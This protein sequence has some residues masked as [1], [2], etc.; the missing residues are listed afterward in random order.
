LFSV[1]AVDPEDIE[2]QDYKRDAQYFQTHP[3]QFDPSKVFITDEIIN[4]RNQA[5]PRKMLRSI[6][7]RRPLRRKALPSPSPTATNSTFGNGYQ[8]GSKIPTSSLSDNEVFDGN[9]NNGLNGDSDVAP[10][11]PKLQR[12][13]SESTKRSTSVLQKIK[14]FEARKR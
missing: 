5:K 7:E 2:T 6:S 12:S 11:V 1:L 13:Q 10:V 9:N 14:R 8:S 4:S 3:E